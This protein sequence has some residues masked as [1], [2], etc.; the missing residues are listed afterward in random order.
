MAEWTKMPLGMEVGLGPGDFVLDG[1]PAPPRKGAQ[2]PIFGT[3]WP[4]SW[5]DQDTTWSGGRPGPRRH[6]VRCGSSSP[7]PK[8][9]EAHPQF[10]AHVYYSQ[11]ARW[12]K[13]PIGRQVG[14]GPSDIVLDGDPAPP[15]GAQPPIFSPRPLRPNGW[16]LLGMEVGL[17]PGDFVFHGD[18]AP[19]PQKK[20]AQPPNF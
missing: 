10:T 18:Q 13:M 1:D 11:M 20:E 17:G 19:P 6:C 9:K 8:K 7:P 16:M 5:M 3:L 14:L 12:I 2:P 15:N 4:N